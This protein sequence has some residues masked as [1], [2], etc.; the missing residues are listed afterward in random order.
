MVM[1]RLIRVAHTCTHTHTH[2]KVL[3]QRVTHSVHLTYATVLDWSKGSTCFM[4]RHR[5]RR[6]EG[7]EEWERE[8]EG[9]GV[10]EWER[11]RE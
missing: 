5:G 4:C 2:T 9:E 10:E 11:G 7:R 3:T 8:G 6:K 1:E